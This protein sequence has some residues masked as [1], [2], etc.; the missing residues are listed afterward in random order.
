VEGGTPPFP[1]KKEKKRKKKKRERRKIHGG[2]VNF[3]SCGKKKDPERVYW[4]LGRW[5]TWK[6]G[7]VQ[8][9]KGNPSIGTQ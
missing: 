4:L 9:E 3:Q 8:E 1:K 6:V 7:K 2:N 5:L